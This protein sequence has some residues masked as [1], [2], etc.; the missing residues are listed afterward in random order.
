MRLA[1][2]VRGTSTDVRV[3]GRARGSLGTRGQEAAGGAVQGPPTQ[4]RTSSFAL[5]RPSGTFLTSLP[6][7][8]EWPCLVG[9]VSQLGLSVGGSYAA[10]TRSHRWRDEGRQGAGRV[11][12][13]ARRWPCSVHPGD[14]WPASRG[15]GAQA[16]LLPLPGPRPASG[17][18]DP[19]SSDTRPLLS[20]QPETWGFYPL[21]VPWETRPPPELSLARPLPLVPFSNH[22]EVCAAHDPPFS[23]DHAEAGHEQI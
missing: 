7:K 9:G 13:P 8:E 21:E 1:L 23:S 4:K 14:P 6:G 12:G 10:N 18:S 16:P 19:S 20:S 22:R 15:G 17:R 2:A 11:P 5:P 3:C